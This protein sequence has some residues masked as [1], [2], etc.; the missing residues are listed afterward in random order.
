[1]SV[2]PTVAIIGAGRV[3]GALARRFVASGLEVALG[4]RR[5][6]AVRASFRAQGIEVAAP[7]EAIARA[8]IV[9][10]AVP[11][12]VAVEVARE[13]A[14]ALA[15]KILVDCNNPVG[16]DAEGL[17][18]RPPP[19]GSLAAALAAALPGVAVVKAF[20]TFGAELHA[21]PVIDERGVDVLVAGEDRAKA[22]VI[23]LAR[24][25]GFEPVDAGPLR[26]AALL[27]ALA[28]LWIH[29]ATAGGHGR[30]FSF[31]IRRR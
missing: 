25:A 30:G 11:G 18:H 15:G 19:E 14:G 26:N 16:R 22:P 3:G 28:V 4:V 6:D 31:V 7:A 2:S 17:V 8:Q 12:P 10:L 1:M 9:F 27:E 23:A 5:P 13:H 24:T 29:L 20:N 21:D